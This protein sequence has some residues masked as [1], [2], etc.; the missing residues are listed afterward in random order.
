M[1]GL[2]LGLPRSASLSSSD[3]ADLWGVMTS[4]PP[5][6]DSPVPEIDP[7]VDVDQDKTRA[8]CY[9][10]SCLS[11]TSKTS[12]RAIL[13]TGLTRVGVLLS[14]EYIMGGEQLVEAERVSSA[15]SNVPIVVFCNKDDEYAV[16]VRGDENSNDKWSK[17]SSS[18][19]FD[20]T[21]LKHLV[22][23]RCQ[24]TYELP[25][26]CPKRTDTN[27]VATCIRAESE[28]LIHASRV[29]DAVMLSHNFVMLSGSNKSLG[30]VIDASSSLEVLWRSHSRSTAASNQEKV[31]KPQSKKRNQR[32]K[33]KKGNRKGKG[34]KKT[35]TKS[36]LLQCPDSDDDSEYLN[37]ASSCDLKGD[38]DAKLEQN[39]APIEMTASGSAAT[40]SVEIVVQ[41]PETSS[42]PTVAHSLSN[43]DSTPQLRL[44]MRQ[45][46]VDVVAVATRDLPAAAAAELIS[47]GIIAQLKS[48]SEELVRASQATNTNRGEGCFIPRVRP[49][50]FVFSP[51]M[52]GHPI[53]GVFTTSE[54][55][56]QG[57]DKKKMLAYE[58]WLTCEATFRGELNCLCYKEAWEKQ[59]PGILFRPS[60]S[61]GFRR[62]NSRDLGKLCSVHEHCPAPKGKGMDA[63]SGMEL[64]MVRGSYRYYH[65]MQDG[66]N[67]KGWGC[68]YRSL[69]TLWSWF[70][71]NHYTLKVPPTHGEIQQT[72]VD[73]G[74][75]PQHFVGSSD[76]IGSQGVGWCLNE[77]L[78]VDSKY[79]FVP[80]GDQLPTKAREL[81]KHFDTYGT[82]VMM[83]GGALAFTILGVAWNQ[84]TGDAQF[85]I[86]DPHYTGPEDI[87]QIV[88]KEVR[89]EGYRAVPCGWRDAGSFTK[90][91]FY[92]CCLPM[93]DAG[94]F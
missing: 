90:G 4:D 35:G 62:W 67:D 6:R 61:W 28:R 57:D 71:L 77:H 9:V 58:D 50:T 82:P 32:K 49:E 51:G 78:G 16:F 46:S 30:S 33:G 29:N 27:T 34:S 87:E 94:V 36:R 21:A 69:Q 44:H 42:L 8:A 68:A 40:V 70:E 81:A 5:A 24:V 93:V 89:L 20:P 64:H 38:A 63:S 83:G 74:D 25:I 19:A 37:G 91:A 56:E 39:S 11:Q 12:T 43:G 31:G 86:L 23:L 45:L 92:N 7:R 3:P 15:N 66:F 80:S 10:L 1:W 41:Q 55:L 72:L 54:N 75:K 84:K 22:Y 2:P 73:I 85:L 18:V 14:G 79:L 48:L 17:H 47:S 53:C 60:C 26:L 52:L 88:G 65:Y 59:L 76:W 13:P